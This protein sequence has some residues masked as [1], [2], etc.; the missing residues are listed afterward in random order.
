MMTPATRVAMTMPRRRDFLFLLHRQALVGHYMTRR[1]S[2]SIAARANGRRMP[3]LH[4]TTIITAAPAASAH[5]HNIGLARLR[6]HRLLYFA[7]M[8][9]SSLL[10]LR[11]FFYQPLKVSRPQGA[12]CWIASA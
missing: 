6:R 10:L 5:F 3:T 11:P 12:A 1:Y 7:M 4:Y 2:L 8:H 9:I